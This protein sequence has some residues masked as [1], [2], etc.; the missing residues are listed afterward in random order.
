MKT[1]AKNILRRIAK[2]IVYGVVGAC[3]MGVVS[4]VYFLNLKPDLKIWHT[5]DLDEEFTVESKVEDF[6]GYLELEKRLFAQ[7]E[8]EV[9]A[10]I[11]VEDQRNYNRYFRGGP[12]DPEREGVNW[13]RSFELPAVGVGEGARPGVLLLHGLSDS[14]YSLRTIGKRLNEAGAH[15]IGLRIPG[16]GTVPSGLVTVTWQD[17]AAAVRLAMRHLQEQSRGGPLYVVGYSNGAA[18]AVHYALAALEDPELPELAGMALLSAEIGVS[19]M[20]ALA[21]WQERLGRITGLDKLAWS[22][23]LPEYDPYKY[24]SF[25]VN[26]GNLAY[27]LTGVNRTK[28][29]Q[30]SAAGKLGAFPP[31]LAFQSAVDATVSVPALVRD[32]FGKLPEG[33]HEL[34]VFDLNRTLAI[35]SLFKSD[36][37]QEFESIRHDPDRTFALSLL[38]NTSEDSQQVLVRRWPATGG[39]PVESD[40]GLAWPVGLYSLSHVAL[41][42][43]QHDSVYGGYPPEGSSG[44]HLGALDLRG[45]RGVLQVSARDLLRLRWNPFYPYLE[46]RVLAHFDLQTPKPGRAG[47]LH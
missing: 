1:L 45:E 31:V 29:G 6:A 47:P 26:A 38:T 23:V 15:V 35:E 30:L 27:R 21:I 33:G 36:P 13:N 28:I 40:L 39:A 16:H 14:P 19:R 24:G 5:V 37:R 32:F 7:L 41:P 42:F 4:G 3:G 43:P 34:V 12:S 44:I 11:E 22:D 9:C 46:Q 17:M 10:Q 8:S 25:A 18:L 20:A 2:A